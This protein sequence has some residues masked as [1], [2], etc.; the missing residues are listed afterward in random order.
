M[1]L[2]VLNLIGGIIALLIGGI[3]YYRRPEQKAFLLLM[4]I[5]GVDII[6]TGMRMLLK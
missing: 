1:D 5:G 6:I 4:A 3:L 2:L